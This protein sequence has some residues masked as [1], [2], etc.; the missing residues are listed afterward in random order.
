MIKNHIVIQTGIILIGIFLST[1]IENEASS[2]LVWS[3]IIIIELLLLKV[4]SQ[5]E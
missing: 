5:T 4:I 1:Y 3:V 2:H